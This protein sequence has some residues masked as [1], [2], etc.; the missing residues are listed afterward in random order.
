M[1]TLLT[2]T[3]SGKTPSD[4][5]PNCTGRFS[6]CC[7]LGLYLSA[8]LVDVNQVGKR[9]ENA[10]NDENEGDDDDGKLFHGLL[11]CPWSDAGFWID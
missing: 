5:A 4:I 11:L 9:E 8:V 10:D 3:R 1:M 2:S 6:R 7:R